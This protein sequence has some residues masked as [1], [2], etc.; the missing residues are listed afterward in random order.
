MLAPAF[1]RENYYSTEALDD[2][3]AL[4]LNRHS[5]GF[6]SRPGVPELTVK[7]CRSSHDDAFVKPVKPIVVSNQC[8]NFLPLFQIVAVNHQDMSGFGPL[9]QQFSHCTV[10]SL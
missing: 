9:F 6:G 1:D 2:Q 7:P 10:A 4:A 3:V 8:D 5:C